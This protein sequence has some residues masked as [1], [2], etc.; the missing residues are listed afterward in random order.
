M[1]N[2]TELSY[3]SFPQLFDVMNICLEV[4]ET[5]EL[6]KTMKRN[7]S[8]VVVLQKPLR[9]YVVYQSIT[10]VLYF[11]VIWQSGV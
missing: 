8:Y 6:Y 2:R 4:G 10:Y 7:I 5:T 3:Y 9:Q 11:V 1:S